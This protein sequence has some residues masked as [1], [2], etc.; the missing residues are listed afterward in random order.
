MYFMFNRA[1]GHS[2]PIIILGFFNAILTYSILVVVVVVVG[3]LW[4]WWWW[5]YFAVAFAEGPR[6]QPSPQ[7][8]TYVMRGNLCLAHR[9]ALCR[10]PAG[11]SPGHG[12]G[13]RVGEEARMGQLAPTEAPLPPAPA[14]FFLSS[15]KA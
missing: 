7:S 5:W 3:W 8:I 13:W 12:S 14:R 4:W 15:G 2:I 11:P 10:T 1:C 6:A 9:P